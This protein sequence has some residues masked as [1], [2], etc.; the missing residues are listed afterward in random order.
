VIQNT[1]LS[2]TNIKPININ[3]ECWIGTHEVVMPGVTIG[4]GSVIGALSLERASYHILLSLVRQ[5][6]S[7]KKDRNLIFPGKIKYNVSEHLPYFYSSF[8]YSAG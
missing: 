8:F 7:I 2:I 3:E 6:E 5:P 4:K 1:D